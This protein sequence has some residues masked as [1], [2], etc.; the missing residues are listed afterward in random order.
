MLLLQI[1]TRQIRV[2]KTERVWHLKNTHSSLPLL[3]DDLIAERPHSRPVHLRPEMMFGMVA[4]VEPCPVIESAVRAHPPCNW[5]IGIAPVMPVVTVQVRQAMAEI[6]KGQKE[7]DIMP[8]K[9]TEH[10]KGRNETHQLE[11]SPKRIA[12]V[13]AFQLLEDSL[14]ILAKK[15]YKRV[16]QRMLGFTVMAVFVNRNPINGLTLFV[17]QV[18]VSLVMLHVNALV[19]D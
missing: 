6:P 13:L 9:N 1:S 14:W 19:K 17:G 15:T 10:Y 4:I 3:L 7:T 2:K 8:V 11:H 18:G 5:L 16:F 12:R